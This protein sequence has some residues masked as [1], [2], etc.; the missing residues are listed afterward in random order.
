MFSQRWAF[1]WGGLPLLRLQ[2]AIVS[3]CAFSVGGAVPL[4]SAAFISDY[5]TRLAVLVLSSTL[6]F[7]VFGALGAAMGGASWGRAM[8]RGTIG[9]WIAMGITF[10]ALFLFGEVGL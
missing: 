1:L 2:A 4:L 10:L 7:M 6:A 3:G 9:G 8:A 5:Q